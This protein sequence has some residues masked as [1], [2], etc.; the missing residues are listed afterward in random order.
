[1]MNTRIPIERIGALI[2]KNGEVKDQ[3]D[4]VVRALAVHGVTVR[5]RRVQ[6]DWVALVGM[7]T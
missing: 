3:A 2:G 6:K 1:M 7:K 4:D 5:E